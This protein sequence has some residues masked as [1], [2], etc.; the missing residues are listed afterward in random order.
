MKSLIILS[1]NQQVQV[2]FSEEQGELLKQRSEQLLTG[3][4]KKICRTLIILRSED[5]KEFEVLM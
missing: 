3:I 4:P 2:L 5:L 1:E